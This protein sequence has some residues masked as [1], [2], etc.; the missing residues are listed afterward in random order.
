[1]PVDLGIRPEGSFSKIRLIHDGVLILNTILAL[2]RDYKPLTF[3]GI[4]GLA[5]IIAGLIPGLVVIVEYL[6]TGLVLRLPSAVLAVGL[7]SAGT[8]FIVA[9][10]IVHTITRRFQELDYKLQLLNE[11]I[12][13]QAHKP[14]W[15]QHIKTSRAEREE[16]SLHA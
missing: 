15:P 12:L 1:V 14:V 16:I 11:E 3:F 2:F 5:L 7:V 9:G 8:L 4:A 6:R 13:E 10:V